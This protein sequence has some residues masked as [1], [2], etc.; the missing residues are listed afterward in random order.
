MDKWLVYC[1]LP[2]YYCPHN[3]RHDYIVC[4]QLAFKSTDANVLRACLYRLGFA[5]NEI[6][7]A[8]LVQDHCNEFSGHGK[9][10]LAHGPHGP[11]PRTAA[12]VELI[13][14]LVQT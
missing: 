3:M 2:A 9:F 4:P 11:M 12:D 7:L 5:E 14:A 1:T 13:D 8:K 10:L 6:E